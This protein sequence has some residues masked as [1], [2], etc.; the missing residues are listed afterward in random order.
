MN[1]IIKIQLALADFA[2]MNDEAIRRKISQDFEIDL[3]DPKLEEFEILLAYQEDESYESQAWFLLQD[4]A[5]GDLWELHASHC[6][7]YGY[8]GLWTPEKTTVPYLQ[9]KHFSPSCYDGA[10]RTAIMEFVAKH[11]PII[12][13]S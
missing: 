11:F 4:R 3:H 10:C 6:S 7:C 5:T 8:E 13:P 9:S 2:G 1:P 12:E